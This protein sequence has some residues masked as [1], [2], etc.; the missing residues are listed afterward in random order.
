MDNVEY[1]KWL[2]LAT[3]L[4]FFL[5]ED[6]CSNGKENRAVIRRCVDVNIAWDDIEICVA[7]IENSKC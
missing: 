1:Y 4:Y 7:D 2:V 5:R 3:F 6:I